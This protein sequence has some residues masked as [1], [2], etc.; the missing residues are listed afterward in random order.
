MAA[1]IG[2]GSAWWFISAGLD[3]GGVR[4]GAW[5]TNPLIGGSDA[6]PYTRAAVARAGLLAL[7][8][9]ET[10][11]FNASEDDAGEPLSTSCTYQVTGRPLASRWWSITAYGADH[12]LI[13]NEAKQYSQSMNSVT[14]RAD[15]GF[16][17]QVGPDARGRDA[18][19][20]GNDGAAFSLTLRLYNPAA[21]VYDNLASVV[22]PRIVKE[23]CK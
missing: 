4:N 18:I 1:A 9:T 10:V 13:P 3:G 14:T 6:D 16:Q 8:K 2:L 19:Q 12:F 11:Y 17:I 23:G 5:I 7:N 20:T 15:G 21:E 22:L